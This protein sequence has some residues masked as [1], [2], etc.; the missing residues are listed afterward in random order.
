[1]GDQLYTNAQVVLGVVYNPI[2]GELYSAVRGGGAKL[3]GDPISVSATTD[4]ASALFATEAR[5]HRRRVWLYI[6]LFLKTC[7]EGDC[8]VLFSAKKASLAY[9]LVLAYP[10]QCT[11]V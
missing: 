1:M 4:L 3:N 9:D 8:Y 10:L 7:W 11:Y 6:K 2:L 5:I